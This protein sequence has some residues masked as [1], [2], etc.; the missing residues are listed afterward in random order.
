MGLCDG[1]LRKEYACIT[2]D[3]GHRAGANQALWAAGSL[4]AKVDFGYRATH[5]TTLAG[6]P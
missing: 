1:P 6:K 3:M 5:V 4:Q 2:T